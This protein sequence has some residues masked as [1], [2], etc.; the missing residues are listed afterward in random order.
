M[1]NHFYLELLGYCASALIAVSL[2]MSSIKRLRI[3]ALAMA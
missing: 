1:Q 3:I 2:M